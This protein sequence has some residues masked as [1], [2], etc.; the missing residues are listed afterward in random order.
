MNFNFNFSNIHK[1]VDKSIIS[2]I[3]WFFNDVDRN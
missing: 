3:D 1:P 2:A